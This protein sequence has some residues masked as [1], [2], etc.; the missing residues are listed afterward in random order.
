MKISH[1]CMF[2]HLE[3]TY[4]NGN[5]DIFVGWLLPKTYKNRTIFFYVGI[6]HKVKI[7]IILRL[8][9]IER[10]PDDDFLPS[11]NDSGYDF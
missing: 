5:V 4:K 7:I 8:S 9:S 2:Q 10:Y 3:N 11:G 1:L 6:I